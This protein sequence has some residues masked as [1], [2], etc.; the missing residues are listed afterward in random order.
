[1]N[2]TRP[3]SEQL[4]SLPAPCLDPIQML[5]SFFP[6]EREVLLSSCS[7]QYPLDSSSYRYQLEQSGKLDESVSLTE[8]RSL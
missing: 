2:P 7:G 3:L 4:R 6:L 1:M 5:L 8:V